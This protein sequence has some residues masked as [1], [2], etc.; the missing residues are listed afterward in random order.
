MSVDNN[1]KLIWFRAAKVASTSIFDILKQHTSIN[2]CKYDMPYCQSG[3]EG[4]FKFCFNRNPWDRVVSYYSDKVI[5]RQL[6]PECCGKYFAYFA[7][8]LEKLDLTKANGHIR[9]QTSCF[10]Q[11]EIDFVGRLENLEE[12]LNFAF[13]KNLLLNVD[14]PHRNKS[15][16]KKYQDYYNITKESIVARLYYEDIKLGNYDF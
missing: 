4:Y 16:R 13:N 2:S 1:R 7:N 14:L 15:S 6:F 3:Y 9:L 5:K 8:Y 10:P 12:D 11:D